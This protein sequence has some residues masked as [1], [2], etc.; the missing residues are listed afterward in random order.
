MTRFLEA[1]AKVFRARSWGCW[2][3]ESAEEVAA[4]SG[5]YE[6][7]GDDQVTFVVDL[8]AAV[9]HQP[10][11]GSFDDPAFGEDREP[12]SVDTVHDFD[13][14]VVG[15]AVLDEGLFEPGVAPQA[16]EP[17]RTGLGG[18]G[19]LGATG[20]VRSVGG[21]DG[22]CQQQPE[23]VDNPECFTTRDLLPGVIT[24]DVAGTVEVPRTV[25]ASTT[26]ADGSAS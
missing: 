23:G 4:V 15:T 24:P 9:V 20:V 22:D 13:G 19:D 18:V 11:P 10:R 14:D 1:V 7:F 2:L 16:A 26:P 17:V 6:T 3:R 12:M 8:E 21:D 25:R 5:P